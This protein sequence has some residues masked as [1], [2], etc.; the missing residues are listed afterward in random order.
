[1]WLMRIIVF[2]TV[3][4]LSDSCNRMP[5]QGGHRHVAVPIMP[6]KVM[7]ESHSC[8]QGAIKIYGNITRKVPGLL[9]GSWIKSA[10][11]VTNALIPGKKFYCLKQQ[12]FSAS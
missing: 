3:Q 8:L 6:K 12:I 4:T 7:G 9:E 10:N 1:M 5:V 2:E 11:K